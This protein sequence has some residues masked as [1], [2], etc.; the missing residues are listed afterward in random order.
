MRKV[1]LAGV[2][3]LALSASGAGVAFAE[4][5]GGD[6]GNACPQSGEPNPP[7]GCGQAKKQPPAPPACTLGPI[8]TQVDA[9]D[10]GPLDAT[11]HDVLCALA[12]N[13]ITL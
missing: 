8:L 13:G 3:A 6:K 7:P 1:F 11:V 12:E 5:G 4:R 2:L 10:F 9:A